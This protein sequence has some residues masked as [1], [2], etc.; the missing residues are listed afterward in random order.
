MIDRKILFLALI[1]LILIIAI[2]FI[3]PLIAFAILLLSTLVL[4][5]YTIIM[6]NRSSLT[7]GVDDEL[8]REHFISDRDQII[9]TEEEQEKKNEVFKPIG[10]NESTPQCNT[11]INVLDIRDGK[12]TVEEIPTPCNPAH[13]PTPAERIAFLMH[14]EMGHNE[15]RDWW[16]EMDD[17]L[18][19]E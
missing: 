9:Y 12:E 3:K 7:K 13:E 6:L 8:L 10:F 19:Y 17:Y 11:R 2:A 4:S 16:G 14:D 15:E 18:V 5:G 1:I